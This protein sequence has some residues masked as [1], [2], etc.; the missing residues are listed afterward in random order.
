MEVNHT[1]SKS[2]RGH[3]PRSRSAALA[4]PPWHGTHVSR[5]AHSTTTPSSRQH[6]PPPS[7]SF[8]LRPPSVH[9][10]QL[11]CAAQPAACT[12]QPYAQPSPASRARTPL[13]I[14]P[15]NAVRCLPPAIPGP[16]PC[17]CYVLSSLVA[18]SG[19]FLLA[20]LCPCH[21]PGRHPCMFPCTVHTPAHPA[22]TY[23]SR[24]SPCSPPHHTPYSL[25]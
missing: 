6:S 22:H 20:S 3:G 23:R 11:L 5:R 7:R 14:P 19:A 4:T 13:R 18:P 16:Q 12:A 9:P 24:P 15:S 21:S 2:L 25:P 1:I 17:F 10:V 8:C